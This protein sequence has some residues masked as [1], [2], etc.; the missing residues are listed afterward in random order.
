MLIG[1][2]WPLGPC[3]DNF[4]PLGARHSSE[5]CCRNAQLKPSRLSCLQRQRSGIWQNLATA[6]RLAT[7]EDWRPECVTPASASSVTFDEQGSLPFASNSCRRRLRVRDDDR[8]PVAGSMSCRH[9]S[10][11]SHRSWQLP[12]RLRHGGILAVPASSRTGRAR[13]ATLNKSSVYY[14]R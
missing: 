3:H 9:G 5:K 12:A 6:R 2:P 1:G 14:R 13:Y 4:R 8:V 10:H 7:A 11:G